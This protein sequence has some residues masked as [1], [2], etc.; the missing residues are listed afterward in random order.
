MWTC[1]VPVAVP[2]YRRRTWQLRAWH[3]R[4]RW[5]I[6]TS[7]T[8]TASV[9]HGRSGSRGAG[10]AAARTQHCLPC[11]ARLRRTCHIWRALPAPSPH[12]S[13]NPSP[14]PNPRF[15]PHR[16]SKRTH[17]AVLSGD[18]VARTRHLRP[19]P[20]HAPCAPSPH[21]CA[22]CWLRTSPP[23]CASSP[24]YCAHCWLRTIPPP[25][26][27]SPRYCA[28]CWLLAPPPPCA[29]SPRYCAHCWLQAPPPPCAPIPRYCAHSWLRA[30]PSQSLWPTRWTPVW[31]CVGGMLMLARARRREA[32]AGPTASIG[33]PC[34]GWRA[35]PPSVRSA[36]FSHLPSLAR[37]KVPSLT[38]CK[39]PRL[40]ARS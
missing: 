12:P 6:S 17:M 34:V 16:R 14:T 23:P 26:A 31:S 39:V 38:R 1:L 32:G 36:F 5:T 3:L 18:A 2:V 11:H 21:Y 35:A 30:P 29:P 20:H 15:E 7:M 25:C 19:R 22:H 27:H 8:A 4:P 24:R 13:P 33:R 10:D 28:H 37:C 9:R 40:E